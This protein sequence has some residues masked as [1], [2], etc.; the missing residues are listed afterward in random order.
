[1]LE[2]KSESG[3]KKKKGLNSWGISPRV[4]E[5]SAYCVGAVVSLVL[6][7]LELIQL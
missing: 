5:T 1:M 2:V 3:F 4:W 7:V 6:G